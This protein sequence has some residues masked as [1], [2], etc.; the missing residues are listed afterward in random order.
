MTKRTR[1]FLS[2]LGGI[3]TVGLGTGLVAAYVGGFENLNI[4]GVSGPTSSPTSLGRHG[5]AFANVREIM[6]SELHQKLSAMAP[7]TTTAGPL[8]GGDG[9]RRHHGRGLRACRDWRRPT[10]GRSAPRPPLVMARGRFD[11]VR[12]EGVVRS[13]G[14][15]GR[16]LQGRPAAQG[17][18]PNGSMDGAAGLRRAGLIAMG[19][20]AGRPPGHR[21][22]TRRGASASATRSSCGW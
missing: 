16:G 8:R 13:K 6:D 1:L 19:A 18:E 5:R 10:P 7:A 15:T 17:C 20:D 3:L 2:R 11:T 4:L 21:L 14:G 9:R 12:V 22:P